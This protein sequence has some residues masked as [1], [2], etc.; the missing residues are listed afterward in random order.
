MADGRLQ[1]AD[2]QKLTIVE[3][4]K[5]PKVAFL[6]SG[7][8]TAPDGRASRFLIALSPCGRLLLPSLATITKA[9][10]PLHPQKA[11]PLPNFLLL[12]KMRILA[13]DR[14]LDR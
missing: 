2:C 11:N 13:T 5:L 6:F 3:V 7:I 1:I 9:F 10:H 4:G 8:A 12:Y 14:S